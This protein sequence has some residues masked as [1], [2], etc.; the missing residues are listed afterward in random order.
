[1][2]DAI[3]EQEL[4]ALRLRIDTGKL[5]TMK[6]RL[7]HQALA[8]TYG[9]GW[10]DAVTR[11]CREVDAGRLT[12][13]ALWVTDG[14]HP[15]DPGYREFAAAAWD[16]YMAAVKAKRAPRVPTKPTRASKRRRLEGKRQRAEVKAGRRD[17]ELA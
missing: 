15:H 3:S 14:V 10:G 5:P 9:N 2:A 4:Q 12:R 13:E 17:P 7:A 11:I 1:M 16:G 6:R 8:E